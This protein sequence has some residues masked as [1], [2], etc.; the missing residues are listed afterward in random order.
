MVRLNLVRITAG[1]RNGKFSLAIRIVALLIG[2]YLGATIDIVAMMIILMG[3]FIVAG[4]I[5]RR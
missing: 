2:R 3:L 1:D 4:T 5:A